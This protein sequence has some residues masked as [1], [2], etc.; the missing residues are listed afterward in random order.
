MSPRGATRPPSRSRPGPV[1]QSNNHYH[2]RAASH[3]II[4]SCAVPPLAAAAAAAAAAVVR[5]RRR[6][7]E[8]FSSWRHF[9]YR[10]ADSR[11][12]F[13]YDTGLPT[14]DHGLLCNAGYRSA[15]RL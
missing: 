11:A 15:N 9:V 14:D 6:T 7:F 13:V 1:V 10:L 4:I 3:R 2:R 5:R 12:P 8:L